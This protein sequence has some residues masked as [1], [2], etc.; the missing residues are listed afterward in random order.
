MAAA[1]PV[2]I[3]V[4]L[5]RVVLAVLLFRRIT[6]CVY[7]ATVAETSYFDN[8]RGIVVPV[9]GFTEMFIYVHGLLGAAGSGLFF[10]CSCSYCCYY[11][12]LF[13]WEFFLANV[14]NCFFILYIFVIFMLYL[15]T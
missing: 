10:G 5:K 12:W 1:A 8:Y 3:E 9:A 11:S 7:A 15:S 13:L 14:V 4:Q 6:V 2:A